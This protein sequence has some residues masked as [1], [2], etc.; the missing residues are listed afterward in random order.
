MVL[1]VGGTV[2]AMVSG[3]AVAGGSVVATVVVVVA[4]IV[5]SARGRLSS[6]APVVVDV[7]GVSALDE[8]APARNASPSRPAVSRW[9]TVAPP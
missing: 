5:V 4:S 3:G 8:H 7:A 2:G 9:F 6:T 1:V